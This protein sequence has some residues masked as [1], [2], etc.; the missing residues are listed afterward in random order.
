MF[1]VENDPLSTAFS[2]MYNNLKLISSYKVLLKVW[3]HYAWKNTWIWKYS[4]TFETDQ[5]RQMHLTWFSSIYDRLRSPPKW[6]ILEFSISWNLQKTCYAEQDGIS[7]NICRKLRYS[8]IRHRKV[9]DKSFASKHTAMKR[10]W[11]TP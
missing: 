4:I 5:K 8:G 10:C 1:T 3:F 6:K 9:A 7:Y 2:P 11:C